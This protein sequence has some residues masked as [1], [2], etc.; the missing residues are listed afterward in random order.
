MILLLLTILGVVLRVVIFCR[1]RLCFVRKF[2]RVIGYRLVTGG[3]VGIACG[4]ISGTCRLFVSISSKM[5]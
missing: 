4:N 2:K 3:V 5:R 1:D